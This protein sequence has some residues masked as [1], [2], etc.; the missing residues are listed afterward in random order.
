[1]TIDFGKIAF[2]NSRSIL[3]HDDPEVE[4][5]DYV[6]F[7]KSWAKNGEATYWIEVRRS[8]VSGVNEPVYQIVAYWNWPNNNTRIIGEA[9]RS[10]YIYDQYLVINYYKERIQEILDRDYKFVDHCTSVNSPVDSAVLY[11]VFPNLIPATC[12]VPIKR[13]EIEEEIDINNPFGDPSIPASIPLVPKLSLL[14]QMRRKGK[15]NWL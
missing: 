15:K 14:E 4:T 1:M 9:R 11:T 10:D 3:N 12:W 2:K 8:K 5:V 7:R 6:S 13:T